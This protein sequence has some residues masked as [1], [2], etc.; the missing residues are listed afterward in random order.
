MK[1]LTSIEAL[2]I[3]LDILVAA[4]NSV[5]TLGLGTTVVEEINQAPCNC[6][7]PELRLIT[8]CL[9]LLGNAGD[10]GLFDEW[11]VDHLQLK[12]RIWHVGCL[13]GS[14]KLLTIFGLHKDGLCT[15]ANGTLSVGKERAFSA[16]LL[17]LLWWS[18]SIY[19]LGSTGV[20]C[21]DV[22]VGG[23]LSGVD[24]LGGLCWLAVGRSVAVHACLIVAKKRVIRSA[25]W[26]SRWTLVELALRR[27]SGIIFLPRVLA[28]EEVVLVLLS[29]DISADMHRVVLVE[30]RI[31]TVRVKGTTSSAWT[32]ISA[33]GS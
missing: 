18:W 30:H 12:W 24:V 26:D 17:R 22:L 4:G 3:L 6:W 31:R 14:I 13:H 27:S 23:M 29:F 16:L 32:S 28:A 21:A 19:G 11:L 9:K 15:L 1:N 8:A 25:K 33:M 20:A 10:T 2:H 7:H 5:K